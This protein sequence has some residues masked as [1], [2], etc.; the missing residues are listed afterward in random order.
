MPDATIRMLLEGAEDIIGANDFLNIMSSTIAILRT[1]DHESKWSIGSA[2]R[3]SPLDVSLH[4]VSDGALGAIESF[5]AGLASLES[6]TQ[7]PRGFNDQV[8]KRVKRLSGP[9][10]AG[11]KELTFVAEG[12]SPVRVS[13]R[14]AASATDLIYSPSYEVQTELEGRLGQITVHGGTAEFCIYDPI[15][16]NPITCKFNPVHAES[17]GGLITHRLRVRGTARYSSAHKPQAIEV[18]SWEGPIGEPPVSLSDIH[19]AGYELMSDRSSEEIIRK[20][21]DSD[22]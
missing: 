9:V 12:Q 18:A 10:G 16:G 19:A 4:A 20:L 1:L 13:K 6:K 5:L 11:I 15:S 17:V 3:A 2:S 14:S 7:R 8:L 22:A 21:R